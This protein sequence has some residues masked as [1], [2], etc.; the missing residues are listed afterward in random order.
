MACVVVWIDEVEKGCAAGGADDGGVSRRV[1]GTFLRCLQ[2]RPPGVFVVAT[3]NDRDGLPPE[4]ARK[5]RFDETFFVG[6]PERGQR[7]EILRVQLARRQ[8]DP[9]R[10]DL[11]RLAE[12]SE[13][14]SGA[15]LEAA[16]VGAMYR[17][18]AAGT[19]VTTDQVLA[20]LAQ[21][22]PLSSSAGVSSRAA[23]DARS[24]IPA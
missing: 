18:Y 6:L 21:I 8:R 24:A 11:D 17:A 1:L 19:E 12:V 2:E 15:E 20:E 5:G 7:K 3:C 22:V 16:L 10:F 23:W 9:G 13:R 4:L 14:F